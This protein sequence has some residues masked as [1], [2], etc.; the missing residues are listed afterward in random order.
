[1]PPSTISTYKGLG[2]VESAVG[3]GGQAL[4]NNFKE[5]ADRIGKCKYDAVTLPTVDDDGGEGYTVGSR[6]L[7]DGTEYVCNDPSLGAAVWV[8]MSG[9][10][11]TLKYAISPPID[12]TAVDPNYIFTTPDG[13][14]TLIESI[15]LITTAISGSG[16]GPLWSILVAGSA[17][18]GA[19]TTYSTLGQD[20]NRI[21]MIIKSEPLLS[22]T[23][24]NFNVMTASTYSTHVGRALISY[25]AFTNSIYPP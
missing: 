5:L 7:Y 18:T 2:V 19:P 14:F 16:S 9:D 17:L 12:L 20:S 3:E 15:D 25:L 21:S 10:K 13:N 24:I 11:L 23:V 8:P 1:M 6:W 4:T 22:G